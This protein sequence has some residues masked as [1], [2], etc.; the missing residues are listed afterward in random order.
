MLDQNIAR[1]EKEKKKNQ[2]KSLIE[3]FKLLKKEKLS[4]QKINK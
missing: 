4:I 3:Y 2:C 1:K